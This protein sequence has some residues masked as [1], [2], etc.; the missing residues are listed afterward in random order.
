MTAGALLVAGKAL[1]WF[2]VPLGLAIYELCT[3]RPPRDNRG[4][5]DD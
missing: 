4:A 1:L 3:V 5:T 2:A